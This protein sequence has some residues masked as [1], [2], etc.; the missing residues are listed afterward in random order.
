MLH[1]LPGSE[2]RESVMQKNNSYTGIDFFRMAAALLI[3]TIHTSPL[4]SFT[5]TGDFFLTRIAARIAVPFFFMTSGFFLI[6]RYARNGE[7][8]KHFVKKTAV[9]YGASILIYLPVNIYNGYFERENL[10]P[11]ILK[12]LLFDGTLY[13]LWYLPASIWGAVI[14]WYLVRGLGYKKALWVT[15]FLYLTGLCGDSYYGVI[16]G[17]SGFR[18]FYELVFQI[19]DYT[20]NGIFFAPVFF[21]LGGVIADGRKGRS[22]GKS[23][24]GFGLSFLCMSGEAFT[25]HYFDLQRHDSMYLFLPL[26]MYFLFHGVLYFKGKRLE[27]LKAA[28]LVIYVLH[29][30]VIVAVRPAAR[31]L[32]LWDLLVENSMLHFLTVCVIS[33]LCGIA[34][35]LLWSRCIQKVHAKD[36]Y[37]KKKYLPETERAYVEIHLRNLEHNVKAL[38]G[39]MSPGCRLMAVVKAEA[40]GHGA[41]EIST[42]LDRIGVRAFAVA[43]IDEGIRLRKYG[44]RGEILI[45]GFTNPARVCE[46]KRYD[47]T[48]TLIGYEYAGVLNRKGIGVKVHIKIDTGMHRLGIPA[49]DFEQVRGLFHMKN[50]KICGMYT[51]LCCSESRRPEDI[52]YT[53]KQIER[54]YCLVEEL[55][56]DGVT[57]PPLHIQ[58]SYGL[59]NYPGL[60]CDYVRLGIALYGVLSAPGDDTVK[61][62]D[63]RPVLSLK[64]RVVLIR[65]VKKGETVGY[66][67]CFTAERDSRIA[68][69]SLGYGDGFPRH[70]SCG[71]GKVLIRRQ[72]VPVVGRICMDQLAVD[73]TDVEDA[74]VGDIVTLIGAEGYDALSAPA[75]AEAFGSISNELL[76]RMGPRLS[77]VTR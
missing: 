9:L 69:L 24:A 71:N 7:R 48:Q 4:A 66:G 54:F 70:L 33:V 64:S 26:C 25:L 74:A 34:A 30:M 10:L 53:E 21:V 42:H 50:L 39:I 6:S 35:A 55:A 17:F 8:L 44:I 38:K 31:L 28:S 13:H 75:V 67:R 16:E 72:T 62:P 40:Y 32:H 5:E 49:E 51:H 19:S 58:S 52:S 36:T 77:V 23:M 45:L 22:F 14:A 20:R 57:I 56:A 12:D 63:L 46:L 27:S 47:L 68:I 1:A 73:V 76:C 60:S 61:K 11:N 65:S 37:K 43:A 59:L 41:Y 2:E 15:F 3:I 29:P 18:G